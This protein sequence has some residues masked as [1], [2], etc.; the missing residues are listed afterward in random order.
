MLSFK[1]KDKSA[2]SP[3]ILI[4]DALLSFFLS[5]VLSICRSTALVRCLQMWF[6]NILHSFVQY[7]HGRFF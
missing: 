3:E 1:I 7:A 5:I 4:W 6:K 2:I